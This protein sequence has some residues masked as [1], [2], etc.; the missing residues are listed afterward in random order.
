MFDTKKTL[1]T[2]NKGVYGECVILRGMARTV[3]HEANT[4]YR[5]H[6]ECVIDMT[7]VVHEV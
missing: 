7:R 4:E 2:F 5:Y 1:V 3:V 6:G